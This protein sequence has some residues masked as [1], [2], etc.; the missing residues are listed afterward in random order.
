M[1]APKATFG[2]SGIELLTCTSC[3]RYV[4]NMSIICRDV[5]LL[6]DVLTVVDVYNVYKMRV[7]YMAILCRDVSLLID[8]AGMPHHGM[9]RATCTSSPQGSSEFLR[10]E[11]LRMYIHRVNSVGEGVSQ[12]AEEI[13]FTLAQSAA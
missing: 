10:F 7:K 12:S 13:L 3:I 8:V 5:S 11:A 2:V 1:N 6:I 4:K 9:E